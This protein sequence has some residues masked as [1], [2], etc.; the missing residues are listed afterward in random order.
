MNV[1]ECIRKYDKL[2]DLKSI[3]KFSSEKISDIFKNTQEN[4]LDFENKVI[5]E[6]D[7]KP[8]INIEFL[9]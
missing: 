7:D 4:I 2:H 9:K 6:Y 8:T 3:S 1:R 5:D